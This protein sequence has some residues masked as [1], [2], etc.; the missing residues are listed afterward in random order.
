MPDDAPYR[1]AKAVS[2]RPVRPARDARRLVAYGLDLYRESLGNEAQFRRDYGVYGQK[3]PVWIAAC[4]ARNPDFAVFLTEEDREIG[5]AVMGVDS[6][7]HQLGHVHH[8][9]IEPAWRGQGF[10][11]LLDDYARKTL[12]QAGCVRARLNVTL[13]NARALRFYIAQG[14][15]DIGG[16]GLRHM[17]TPL[18]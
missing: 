8:F 12:K 3:F 13:R 11:G 16:R 2:F 4:A 6:R 18:Q 1:Y 15:T 7:D 10:G 5:M 17:E 14:W 9:Y